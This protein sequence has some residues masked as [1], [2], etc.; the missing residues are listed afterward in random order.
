MKR[1]V[2]SAAVVVIAGGLLAGS[3]VA[4]AMEGET[5]VVTDLIVVI[6][7]K[8]LAIV[9][10]AL[11]RTAIALGVGTGTA[12]AIAAA[13]TSTSVAMTGFTTMLRNSNICR[14]A[15]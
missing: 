13:F 15:K 6:I 8:A 5:D 14:S 7:A 1:F 2:L 3:A 11:S 12:S 10:I 4:K 9:T